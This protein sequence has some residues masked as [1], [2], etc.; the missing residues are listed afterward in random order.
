MQGRQA[1]AGGG[2]GMHGKCKHAG[3]CGGL[4]VRK[5]TKSTFSTRPPEEDFLM[6]TVVI[7]L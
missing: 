5:L 4:S 6:K 2:R 7:A 1:G 3:A